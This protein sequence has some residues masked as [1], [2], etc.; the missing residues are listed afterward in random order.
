VLENRARRVAARGH[1][2]Q[3]V[4]VGAVLNVQA[5]HLGLKGIDTWIN[6]D[7]KASSVEVATI[8]QC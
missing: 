1:G 8:A 2:S 6:C 3:E 5:D 4:N 7:V